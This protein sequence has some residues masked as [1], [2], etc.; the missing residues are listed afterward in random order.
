MTLLD[1]TDQTPR[2][3]LTQIEKAVLKMR[4]QMGEQA[5]QAVMEA[6][7][8]DARSQARVSDVSAGDALQRPESPNGR[9]SGR[10]LTM[11]EGTTIARRVTRVFFPLDEQL[12]LWGH[13]WSESLVKYAVWL[14]GLV[15]YAEAATILNAIG[16]IPIP[17]S[18]IWR[19]VT[20]GGRNASAG[21][22]QRAAS[23]AAPT[24]EELN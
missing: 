1:W 14:S 5:A 21:T 23:V 3:N 10:A 22:T 6:Q 20:C 4:K 9:K 7:A 24:R 16:E 13:H 18:S 11:R 12:A 15:T 17:T 8:G 19:R 2:P